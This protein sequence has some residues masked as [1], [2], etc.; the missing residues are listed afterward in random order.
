MGDAA[1]VPTGL[2]GTCDRRGCD[3]PA[4]YVLQLRMAAKPTVAPVVGFLKIVVCEFH[5]ALLV[6]DDVIDA[7]AWTRICSTFAKAGAPQ[8]DREL[9]RL[10]FVPLKRPVAPEHP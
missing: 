9:L 4:A 6:I 10:H 5:R 8:P 1:T 3:Q 7:P 2:P